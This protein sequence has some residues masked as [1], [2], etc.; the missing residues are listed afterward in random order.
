MH[1]EKRRS[2]S[3]TDDCRSRRKE[4]V[5]NRSAD[6]CRSSG[7]ASKG[8]VNGID[9]NRLTRARCELSLISSNSH[10]L[11]IIDMCRQMRNNANNPA[12]NE[13]ADSEANDER[14]NDNNFPAA[15]PRNDDDEVESKWGKRQTR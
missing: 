3:E 11:H 4:D 10:C 14:D 9:K 2:G 1:S 6:K 12:S 13:A 8:K 15:T 5:D 7:M